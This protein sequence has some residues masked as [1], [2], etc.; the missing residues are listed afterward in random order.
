MPTRHP[1]ATRP[2]CRGAAGR[3]Q[4]STSGRTSD[5]MDGIS[6]MITRNGISKRP[7]PGH[8]T[9]ERPPREQRGDGRAMG[10]SSSKA[11]DSIEERFKRREQQDHWAL[12]TPIALQVRV[13]W[14]STAAVEPR[15]P[16][17][18]PASSNVVAAEVR[19][20]GRR[21]TGMRRNRSARLQSA[22]PTRELSRPR[23]G[24]RDS[25]TAIGQWDSTDARNFLIADR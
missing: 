21:K 7:G 17:R 8:G 9:R 15:A 11:M 3:N 2:D 16:G 18:L 10:E 22:R 6:T 19:Q 14:P 12:T 4:A 23:D 25:G 13:H 1:A 24:W 20:F 5:T